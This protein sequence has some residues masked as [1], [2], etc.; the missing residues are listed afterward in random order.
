M[1][2][3]LTW[4]WRQPQGRTRY[5]PV[6][7]NILADMVGRHLSIPHT[8][9]CVTDHTEGLDSHIEVIEPPRDFEHVK[10][11]TWPDF[12]PQCYRRLAMFRHDAAEIFG[13]DRLISLDLDIVIGGSLDELFGGDWD[14]RIAKGTAESRPYNGSIIGLRCGAR[15][16]VYEQFT[17]AGA[18][19]AGRRFVGSDQA[20][21]A[22]I[23]GPNELVWDASDGLAFHNTW[24]APDRRILAFTGA[25]KPWNCRD[26]WARQ[27]Y[28]KRDAGRCL[29]L[30]YGPT[31]WADVDRALDEPFDAVIASPE[32]AEHWPG[33]IAA[34]AETNEHAAELAW[35]L[36]FDETVWCGLEMEEAA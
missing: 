16:Q 35:M 4:Y 31:L 25:M 8:F 21:I 14:F 5:S 13:A 15:P 19:E 26:T 32:A 20:W 27:H 12:R 9:A 18:K 24:D 6:H 23:L 2:K 22:D 30:G 36:G 29:L 34:V 28:R 17:P 11:E 33:Q 10:S 7:V 3:I 1:L